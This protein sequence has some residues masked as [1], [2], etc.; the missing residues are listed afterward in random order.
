[1]EVMLRAAVFPGVVLVVFL[2][3]KSLMYENTCEG[4]FFA[5]K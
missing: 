2:G 4:G 3:Q 5:S 1:M